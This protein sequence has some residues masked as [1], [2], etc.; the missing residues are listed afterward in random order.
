MS[1]RPRGQGGQAVGYIRGPEATAV[2]GSPE[3]DIYAC[4]NATEDRA[5]K[6]HDPT[7]AVDATH[8]TVTAARASPG[9]GSTV[10]GMQ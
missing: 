6:A 2:V 4:R 10:L 8:Q 7:V 3:A 9:G 5:A 1:P